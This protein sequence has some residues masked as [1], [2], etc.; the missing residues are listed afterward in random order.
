LKEPKSRIVRWIEILSDFYFVVEH[1]EYKPGS[2]PGNAD[3]MSRCEKP[4]DCSCP[5]IEDEK[6]LGCGP[7]RKCAKKTVEI[8][9]SKFKKY[10]SN[11]VD[12]FIRSV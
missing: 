12:Q 7:C 1:V 8:D 2:K 5:D 10:T 9:S 4:R 6:P 3:A 11:S